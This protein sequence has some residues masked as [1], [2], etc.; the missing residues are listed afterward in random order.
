MYRF[1]PYI[2]A[3]V[4]GRSPHNLIDIYVGSGVNKAGEVAQ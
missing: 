3:S 2:T 4:I 1:L